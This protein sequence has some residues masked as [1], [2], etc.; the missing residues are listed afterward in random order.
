MS[1]VPSNSVLE[2]LV[3]KSSGSFIL[4]STLVDFVDDCS[5][6]PHLKLQNTL[7][8]RNGLDPFYAQVFSDTQRGHRFEQVI[9][10]IMFLKLS[11]PCSAVSI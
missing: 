6:L 3:D 9:G 5:D 8:I 10:T 4:A 7:E 1:N 2:Q 11:W